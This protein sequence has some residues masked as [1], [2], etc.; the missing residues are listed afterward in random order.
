MS[1][2]AITVRPRPG[3]VHPTPVSVSF[4]APVGVYAD[5]GTHTTSVAVT[6]A[7]PATVVIPSVNAPQLDAGSKRGLVRS[8]HRIR[9]IAHEPSATLAVTSPSAHVN[10][11]SAKSRVLVPITR[12]LAFWLATFTVVESSA[13]AVPETVPNA[14]A[15]ESPV[16]ADV[17]VS[18]LE[19]TVYVNPARLVTASAAAK[20]RPLVKAGR[21]SMGTV[22]APSPP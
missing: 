5:V 8:G 14:V 18:A 19:P 7:T 21:I 20:E 4:A 2:V 3:T 15:A 11:A 6:V 13:V 22:V 17:T 12:T 16:I 10:T 9:V 1:H